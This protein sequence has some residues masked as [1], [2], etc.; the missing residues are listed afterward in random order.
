MVPRT[1]ARPTELPALPPIDFPMSAAIWPA[2][3]LVTE[4]VT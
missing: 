2:T 4:R 1:I 3:R